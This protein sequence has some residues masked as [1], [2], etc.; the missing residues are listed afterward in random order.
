MSSFLLPCVPTQAGGSLGTGGQPSCS[1]LAGRCP[2]RGFQKLVV[3]RESKISCDRTGQLTWCSPEGGVGVE[4][5]EVG[6]ELTELDP[7]SYLLKI[8]VSL[9][10]TPSPGDKTPA[11]LGG[12]PVEE[13]GS[14]A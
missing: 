11:E 13:K 14:A 6:V 10:L 9:S 8:S 12:S 1:S 5:T 2:T 7:H 4:L 3:G